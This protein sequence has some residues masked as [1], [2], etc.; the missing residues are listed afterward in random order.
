M[1]VPDTSPFSGLLRTIFGISAIGIVLLAVLSFWWPLDVRG[2]ETNVLHTLQMIHIDRSSLYPNPEVIPFNI[3]Q[4]TPLY[5]ILINQLF[6]VLPPSVQ[7]VETARF[8]SLSGLLLLLYFAYRILQNVT[9]NRGLQVIL[10]LCIVIFTFPWF[11]LIRPDVFECAFVTGAVYFLL[12]NN[13]AL[14]KKNVFIVAL[15]T[16]LAI[17]SKQSAL[18]FI[19]IFF[20]L[21]IFRK[22]WV[23]SLFFIAFSIFQIVFLLFLFEKSGYDMSNLFV[24]I[25]KGINNGNDFSRAMR[26]TYLVYSRYFLFFITVLITFFVHILKKQKLSDQTVNLLFV[27]VIVFFFSLFASLKSG[28]AIN[29]FNGSIILQV[30]LFAD[31]FQYIKDSHIRLAKYLIF[32]TGISVA[33]QD[34]IHYIPRIKFLLTKEESQKSS[35]STIS[36]FLQSNLSGKYFYTDIRELALKF[37]SDVAF[38]SMDIHRLTFRKKVF[39]YPEMI[40]SFKDGRIKF[41]IVNKDIQPDIFGLDIAEYYKVEREFGQFVIMSSKFQ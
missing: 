33:S 5:Y 9:A 7:L 22:E 11:Q 10:L 30:L 36:T 31:L 28:S 37:P 19:P 6:A 29:Y 17:L 18:I 41:L 16:T 34:V 1:D 23:N 39:N 20:S 27:N 24:N 14:K 13:S 25:I 40:K 38:F 15:F 2:V 21:F 3:T 12:Y 32:L 35:L 26:M 4:Y 8:L